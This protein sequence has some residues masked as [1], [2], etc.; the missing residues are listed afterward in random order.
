MEDRAALPA[1]TWHAGMKLGL[2]GELIILEGIAQ[3]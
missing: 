3:A 2:F 1:S